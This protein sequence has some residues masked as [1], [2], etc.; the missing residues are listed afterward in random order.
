MR[1]GFNVCDDDATLMSVVETS[2]DDW[3]WRAVE[4]L[5][6]SCAIKVEMNVVVQ[7]SMAVSHVA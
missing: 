4:I 2:G 7:S 1:L 5:W 3:V 6:M